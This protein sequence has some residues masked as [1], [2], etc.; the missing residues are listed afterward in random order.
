MRNGG[1]GGSEGLKPGR[2]HHEK[3]GEWD[4]NYTAAEQE[5]ASSEWTVLW[6]AIS[7]AE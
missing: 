2:S 3:P 5:A 7:P 1:R 4:V 6:A